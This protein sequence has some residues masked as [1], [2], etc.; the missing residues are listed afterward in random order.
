MLVSQRP[1]Q[2]LGQQAAP[3]QRALR[4]VSPR[5]AAGYHVV[6]GP[7]RVLLAERVMRQVHQ[8]GAADR[9][10]ERQEASAPSSRAC[11]RVL[12]TSEGACTGGLPALSAEQ[13]RRA[14]GRQKLD[15]LRRRR[16]TGMCFSSFSILAFVKPTSPSF[17]VRSRVSS[18]LLAFCGAQAGAGPG[19]GPGLGAQGRG[20]GVGAVSCYYFRFIPHKGGCSGKQRC[21]LGRLQWEGS[22]SRKMGLMAWRCQ[23]YMCSTCKAG[24]G[25][26]QLTTS[27]CVSPCW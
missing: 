2:R 17:A 15:C 20:I 18:T 13:A 12:L 25:E 21:V 8:L 27:K 22:C 14:R 24:R 26:L 4:G 1:R 6:P 23:Q 7:R 10:A 5:P 16:E 11:L 3:M 9:R 19:A